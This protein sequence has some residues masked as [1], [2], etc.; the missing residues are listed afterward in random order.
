MSA[1]ISFRRPDRRTDDGDERG[2][3]AA[4]A[5]GSFTGTPSSGPLSR[6]LAEEPGE[7]AF[8]PSNMTP[9]T[10]DNF[11]KEEAAGV[12]LQTAWTFWLDRTSRNATAAEYKANLRKIYSVSTV[13]GFWSVYNHI[14]DV[15]EIS[16]RYYYH[17]MREERPPLWEDPALASGGVWRLKC[18]KKE[19]VREMVLLLLLFV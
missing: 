6:V 14:P 2:G 7:M 10:L 4:G 5:A 9:R 12:P 13:Q 1:P 11:H 8:S 15:S 19:T 3:G 18:S 17:L 16:V